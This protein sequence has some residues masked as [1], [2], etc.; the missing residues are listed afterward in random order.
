MDEMKLCPLCG[1]PERVVN[2]E[3]KRMIHNLIEEAMEKK[4]RYVTLYFG[5]T[6]V[7]V[8]VYPLTEDEES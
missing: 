8:S 1:R 3:H 5:E 2:S 4:D 7:S 6:G